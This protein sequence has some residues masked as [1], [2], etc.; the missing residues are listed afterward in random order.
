MVHCLKAGDLSPVPFKPGTTRGTGKVP[1]NTRESVKE[2]HVNAR[3][4]GRLFTRPTSKMTI[5]W[6]KGRK[7]AHGL[8][9][10]PF[11]LQMSIWINLSQSHNFSIQKLFL[12]MGVSKLIHIRDD[13][14]PN[15]RISGFK[16]YTVSSS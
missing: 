16:A 6:H 2:G 15:L 5:F 4:A 12:P 8:D 14:L 1:P 9:H 13:L 10:Q 11:P 7:W 3:K